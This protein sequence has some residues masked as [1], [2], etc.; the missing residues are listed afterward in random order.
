MGG[1][2][3]GDT[4]NV[5]NETGIGEE[6]YNTLK[7]GQ[8]SIMGANANYY[9]DLAARN[10]IDRQS[11]ANYYTD[12]ANRSNAE[13]AETATGF[14]NMTTLQAADLDANR[15]YYADLAGRNDA[16]RQ[17]SAAR[18]DSLAARSDAL[19]GKVDA[20]ADQLTGTVG[21]GFADTQRALTSGFANQAADTRQGFADT[22]AAV[23]T[24]FDTTNANINTRFDAQGNAINEGFTN[25]SN[26]LDTMQTNVLGGQANIKALVEQY[27]GNLD[28][29]YA[30]LAK[31]Q[32]DASQ[33]LGGLQTNLTA[34]Q[35]DQQRDN[36][37]ATQQRA[38]LAD[39]VAGGFNAVTETIGKTADAQA[40]ILG[41]RVSTLSDKVDQQG[42]QTQQNFS[43]VAR[44]LSQGFVNNSA[45]G[46][47][48]RA[49]F[50]NKL[51]TVRSVLSDQNANLDASTRAQFSEI[52]QAF[53]ENGQLVAKSIDDQG[54]EINRAIDGQGNLLVS[55]FDKQSGQITQQGINLNDT[56]NN[57]DNAVRTG[58]QGL[59]SQ[60]QSF[61][62]DAGQNFALIAKQITSGFDD[63]TKETQAAKQEFVNSIGTIRNLLTDQNLQV[64]DTIRQQYQDLSGAF[65]DTG[66]LISRSVD[67]SGI[68]TARAIDSQ[69]RLLLARFNQNGE[70]I[71]QQSLDLNKMMK[72]LSGSGF[73]AGSNSSMQQ[74]TP[75]SAVGQM[76][77]SNTATPYTGLM[78]PYAISR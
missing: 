23:R 18:F 21:A 19:S 52:S 2:G 61:Q 40:N 14:A 59:M 1:G 60:M 53:D 12:L 34:F 15:N 29:Y 51:N 38:Q 67:A 13:R 33:R 48:S 71:D 11:S 42:Q 4:T 36:T 63:G 66:K 27:G 6:Q 39:S 74:G 65:D 5:T 32:T 35:K 75:T 17:A 62:N 78:T 26:K 47:Q 46:Q 70:R 64:N 9:A 24:G 8:D 3:G 31:G 22:Q 68:Q 50:I 16:D 10:D 69:G 56:L 57:V 45:E 72:A 30:D 37:I 28:R 58:S 77:S 49:E 41:G 55:R 76:V 43:Q 73:I 44:D 25:T 7:G 54:N 20:R